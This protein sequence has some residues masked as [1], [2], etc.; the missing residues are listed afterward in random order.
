MFQPFDFTSV[1]KTSTP[2]KESL[3]RPPFVLNQN[4]ILVIFL[5]DGQVL[6]WIYNTYLRFRQI[7]AEVALGLFSVAYLCM[8]NVPFLSKQPLPSSL[9]NNR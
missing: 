3:M 7:A 6:G 8:R 4:S 5:S 9:A 2:L 1:E